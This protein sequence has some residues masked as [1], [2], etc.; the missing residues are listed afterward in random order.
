MKAT[1]WHLT[2]ACRVPPEQSVVHVPAGASETG[3]TA[4][5]ELA[6]ELWGAE[7]CVSCT[8]E[9][10]AST[11]TWRICGAVTCVTSMSGSRHPCQSKTRLAGQKHEQYKSLPVLMTS[12]AA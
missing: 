12:Y 8:G 7:T 4:S 3:P 5:G 1:W 9:W 10:K 11:D 6:A 2:D